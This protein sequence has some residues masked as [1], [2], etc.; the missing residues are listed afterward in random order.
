MLQGGAFGGEVGQKAAAILG[1]GP[2]CGA[3]GPVEAGEQGGESVNP[4]P[5]DAPVPNTDIQHLRT[6]QPTHFYKPVYRRAGAANPKAA[7]G[8]G[9]GDGAEVHRSCQ[10]AVE[11]HF[12][13]AGAAPVGSRVVIN[14]AV[15]DRL[16]ELIGV[17]RGEKDPRH[18]GFDGLF[19]GL[20]ARIRGG[21]MQ[22]P[23]GGPEAFA[24][25]GGDGKGVGHEKPT[26]DE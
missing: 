15:L 5:L 10:A 9:H 21:L 6:W 3:G 12:G 7:R 14:E 13:Q 24:G 19:G 4:G 20:I 22:G 23:Y 17:G 11:R 1:L 18:V 26:R 25:A 8:V 2:V 16:F